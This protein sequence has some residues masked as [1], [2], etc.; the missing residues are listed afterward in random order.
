MGMHGCE[1]A[2]DIR[3]MGIAAGP[4][5]AGSDVSERERQRLS[6]LRAARLLDTPPEEAFDRLTRLAA[7]LTAAPSALVSLSDVERQ[8]FKSGYGLPEPLATCREL[9]RKDSFCQLVVESGLPLVVEDARTDARVCDIASAREV[10]AYAGMPLTTS[11]GHTLGSFCVV[12]PSPRE[13]SAAQLEV[14]RD[15]AAAAA[16]EIELR[17]AAEGARRREA[18][19]RLFASRIPALAWTTDTELRIMSAYG[20]LAPQLL[21]NHNAVVGT[22]VAATLGGGDRAVCRD[23][24]RR[25]LAGERATYECDLEGCYLDVCLEPLRNEQGE[26]EGVIALGADITERRRLEDQLRQSQKMEAVGQLAAGIA[27][28]FNNLLMGVLGYASLARGDTEVGTRMNGYLERIEATSRR[29]ASLTAQLLAFGRRQTL[30]P[31]DLQLNELISET[32]TILGRLLGEDIEI[33]AQLDPDLAP[34]RADPTHIQQVLF[35]LALNARD[36]MPSGGALTIATMT[37]EVGAAAELEL[38]PG[39]YVQLSV[40][41][42]GVGMPSHVAERAFE[43]FFTTKAVGQGSGLGL[44]SVYGIVKQSRGDIVMQTSIG[45]GTTF[46]VY[47][48]AL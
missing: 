24:H 11:D 19:L 17:I 27:H 29:A 25:A 15:L 34:I 44:A 1:P 35:N 8:F 36:A 20:S 37:V 39:R 21:G 30:Q 46:S 6:A 3:V 13:W 31:R 32:L 5:H 33:A 26:I 42:E 22:T 45:S 47:L 7:R 40:T 28:D 41:D 43:P 4:I 18:E 48:P 16:T 38:A 10:A 12:D 9:P 23:A 2:P 14:L